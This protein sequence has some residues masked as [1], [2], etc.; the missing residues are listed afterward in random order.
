MP[1]FVPTSNSCPVPEIAAK[2]L[3]LVFPGGAKIGAMSSQL[4][5][6]EAEMARALLAQVQVVL[7][8]L[9]PLF[10][11][12]AAVMAIIDVLAAVSSLNPVKIGKELKNAAKSFAA[13]TQILPQVSGPLLVAHVLDL[14]IMVLAGFQAELRQAGLQQAE[15][16]RMQ[17]EL[18][19][20]DDPMAE[21]LACAIKLNQARVCAV[22]ES[23]GPLEPLLE[24]LNI[25]LR[26]L[27]LASLAPPGGFGHDAQAGLDGISQLIDII[28][29]IRRGLPAPPLKASPRC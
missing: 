18:L 11:I 3:E 26:L 21:V 13:L 23:M 8:P 15:I 19:G 7:A 5:Q 29:G 25:F 28:R 20:P 2:G 12:L 4:Y 6:T 27:G 22:A 14:L 17:A 24:L 16:A 1:L 10:D 9:K